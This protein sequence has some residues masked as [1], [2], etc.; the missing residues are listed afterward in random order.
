MPARHP[1][2]Q[3]SPRPAPLRSGLVGANAGQT[4]AHNRQVVL[5]AL[6]RHAPLS[7]TELAQRAGLTKQAIARIVEKL[8]AEGLVVEARRRR[9]LRGQPAIELEIDPAGCCAIGA[10]ID[11]DHLTILAVDG[12][13]RVTARRNYETYFMLPG[14]FIDK[15]T[16]AHADFIAEGHIDPATLAGI[17]L[18]V[19]D[20]LAEVPVPDRPEAYEAWRGFD[21]RAALAPLVDV[22]I[23]IENDANAAALYELDYGVGAERPSFLYMLVDFC[24]GGGLVLDGRCYRGEAGLGGEIGWLPAAAPGS[25]TSGE[26]HPFGNVFALF[27]LYGDLAAHGITARTPADLLALDGRGRAAVSDWL[28]R[29]S[30]H[31]AEAVYHVGLV[32]DPDAVVIGGRL[33]AP[34]IDELLTHVAERLTGSDIPT[35]AVLRGTG[36]EDAAALGAAVLPLAHRYAL[37][38][39]TPAQ[40]TRTPLHDMTPALRPNFLPFG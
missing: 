16:A 29:V 5:Q 38:A 30:V 7:R 39:A 35:P 25:V 13:G 19:P 26:V 18:A 17:G 31:V 32:I 37:G 9:G 14:A 28:R 6:H 27:G 36:S 11:R 10:T 24:L 34:L 40:L 4:A 20:W 3:T 21:P 12:Q 22:P 2:N 8:M 1:A 33:P 15:V 23:L